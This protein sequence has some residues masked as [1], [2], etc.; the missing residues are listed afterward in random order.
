[1]KQSRNQACQCLL[2]ESFLHQGLNIVFVSAGLIKI[3]DTDLKQVIYNVIGKLGMHNDDQN[4]LET[5]VMTR[6]SVWRP[7]QCPQKGA[8]GIKH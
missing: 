2:F 5:A 1:M 8:A 7:P 6:Q 3:L 4:I